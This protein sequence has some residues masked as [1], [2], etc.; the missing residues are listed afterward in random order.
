[1][2]SIRVKL[3]AETIKLDGLL[4]FYVVFASTNIDLDRRTLIEATETGWWYSS[5][6]AGQ[7]RIVVFHTD[8]CDPSAKMARKPDA[9]LDM[10]HKDT[11]H[12]SQTINDIDYRPMSG[13]GTNY[14]RC[15]AAGSSFLSPFGDQADRWCAV[16][17]AAIAFDPLSS[18]GMITAIRMGC[19]V[20]IM[21]AKQLFPSADS[22][23]AIDL[24]SV[25]G[26]FDEA[27]KDYE[28]KKGYFYSQSMFASAFW[29][30][31][32]E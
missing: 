8:D 13:A 26:L 9:F 15:T 22:K 5:Q 2:D 17:D 11:T 3:R 20:G 25:K 6:L 32:R 23:K 27:R 30:R 12:I 16:G 28:K 31:R 19:S 21:L 7:K 1:M 10:L 14:P 24:E 29:Q 18:Q 4:A